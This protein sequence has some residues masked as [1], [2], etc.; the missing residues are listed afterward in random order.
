MYPSVASIELAT[1]TSYYATENIFYTDG[2]MI[3]D[4]AGS[5]VHNK[6]YETVHQLAKIFKYASVV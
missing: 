6:N 1:I 2:S 5:L 3:D 4:V